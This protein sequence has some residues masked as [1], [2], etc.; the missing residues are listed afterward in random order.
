MGKLIFVSILDDVALLCSKRYCNQYN[1][2]GN[3][4][5]GKSSYLEVNR[6]DGR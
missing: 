2:T 4:M 1:A 6:Q 3:R 5:N